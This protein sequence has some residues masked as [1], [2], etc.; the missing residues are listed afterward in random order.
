MS[1]EIKPD[2]WVAW[3]REHRRSFITAYSSWLDAALFIAESTN[4]KRKIQ[5]AAQESLD[6]LA[7]VIADMG[8][9]IRP[10]KLTFLDEDIVDC[11][12]GNR[13]ADWFAKHMADQVTPALW[14]D[15]KHEVLGLAEGPK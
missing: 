9:R 1:D 2:G 5:E 7:S 12:F 15:F 6:V 10:I 3:H 13:C 8:W 11:I 14:N 4:N